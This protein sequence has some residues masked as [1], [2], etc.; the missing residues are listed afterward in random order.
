MKQERGYEMLKAT[1]WMPDGSHTFEA[2]NIIGAGNIPGTQIPFID[3]K[4]SDDQTER[5]TGFTH[6]RFLMGPPPQIEVAKAIP[7]EFKLD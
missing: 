5:F 7:K 3:V 2:P 6:A 4:V 1:I